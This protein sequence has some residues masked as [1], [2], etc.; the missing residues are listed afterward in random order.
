[1][2][3]LVLFHFESIP[4]D[5]IATKL[6]ISL[7]KVKTD[8]LRGRQALAGHLMRAADAGNVEANPLQN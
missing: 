4:Y 7:S 1:R 6:G 5:E 8:I 2:V 3:P